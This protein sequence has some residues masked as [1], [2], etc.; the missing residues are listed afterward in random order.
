MGNGKGGGGGRVNSCCC[1]CCQPRL[2]CHPTHGRGQGKGEGKAAEGREKA[3]VMVGW[4]GGGACGG[5]GRRWGCGNA[6][7]AGRKHGSVC[8]RAGQGARAPGPQTAW[9]AGMPETNPKCLS[10]P[11]RE[12]FSPECKRELYK[13]N[14]KAM[15]CRQAPTHPVPRSPS[16]PPPLR[17]ATSRKMPCTMPTVVCHVSR[18]VP[19]FHFTKSS[20]PVCC[21][22]AMHTCRRQRGQ[23]DKYSA[24]CARRLR[25][26]Q[27]ALRYAPRA[28]VRAPAPRAM[29]GALL[30]QTLL[31]PSAA[32]TQ[33]ARQR[34]ASAMLR[35]A[36]R[37]YATAA[38]S[39]TR[40]VNTRRTAANAC[41]AAPTSKTQT[42]AQQN[43][44]SYKHAEAVRTPTKQQR[45][46]DRER[47]EREGEREG[48]V[49]GEIVGGRSR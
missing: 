34:R 23:R 22:Y 48:R 2:T 5:G 1:C 4:G 32:A 8:G 29:P 13:E 19:S 28:K 24:A 35:H 49:E 26:A 10:N 6:C 42:T 40:P 37:A 21:T 44:Q 15:R 27:S 16:R 20:M 43:T 9:E 31:P 39:G 17:H 7:K 14:E 47:V 30:R 38:A 3:W 41:S 36:A 25:A 11:W 18:H 33:R 45:R 46:R 12:R